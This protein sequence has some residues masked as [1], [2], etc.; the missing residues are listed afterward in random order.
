MNSKEYKKLTF[1]E[2]LRNIHG[3]SEEEVKRF[4]TACSEEG[5]DQGNMIVFPSG[6]D[7]PKFFEKVKKGAER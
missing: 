1:L 4:L 3:W 7:T 5:Y 6:L 2:N